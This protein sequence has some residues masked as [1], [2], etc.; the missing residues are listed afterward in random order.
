[1]VNKS[2]RTE[3]GIIGKEKKRKNTNLSVT[4]SKTAPNVDTGETMGMKSEI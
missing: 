2:I 1:M 3:E 4:M